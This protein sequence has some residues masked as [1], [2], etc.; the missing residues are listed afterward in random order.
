M[1][2]LELER[3]FLAKYLPEDLASFPSR[4]VCDIYVKGE[5]EYLNLRLRSNGGKYEITRKERINDDDASRQIET[6]INLVKEEF[7]HLAKFTERKLCKQRVDYVL[8]NVK[9]EFDIFDGEFKGLVLVDI[10]FEDEQTKDSFATPD[11]CL[12]DVTQEDFI[13]GGFLFSRS[14]EDI[15]MYLQKYN[16]KQII[17]KY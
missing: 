15:E 14:Y 10:E 8:D 2:K 6:T 12:A 3:T 13:A 17:C 16:Y 9:I 11:F 7:D 4:E 5:S 1:K